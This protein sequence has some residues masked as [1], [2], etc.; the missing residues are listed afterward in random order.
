VSHNNND[1][2]VLVLAPVGQDAGAMA[3]LLER[4]GLKVRICC[5]PLECIGEMNAGAGL[6]LLTEEALALE[7]AFD[8]LDQIRTQPAWSELPLIILTSGGES[9]LTQLLDSAARAAG[10]IT[11]LERPIGTTT[12]LRSVEVGLNSRRRQYQVRDLLIKER[13][14][15]E[16]LRELYARLADHTNELE[17]LVELRTAKLAESN[18][19]LRREIKERE[20]AERTR[21]ELR[22]Q[23]TNAQEEERRRIA[24]ELHDQMG[25]NLTALNLGLR[26]LGEANPCCDD[27]AASVRPLQEL[28]AQTARDLHRVALELRPA[29][30]DDLGLVK[31]LRNLVQMWS[32]HCQIEGDFEPGNYDSAGVSTEIETTLYRLIQEAL[33]NVAKHSGAR[34]VSVLLSRTPEQV[35]A[36]VEDD[37][38]GFD[39][40]AKLEA[41]DGRGRLGL[42]GMKERLS[43]IAGKLQ[44]ESSPGEGTTL[45]IRIPIAT[46]K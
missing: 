40:A 37:G 23:L 4:H 44:I 5:N 27:V 12:L 3:D 38:R 6:L 26:S 43:G 45:I 29:A 1:E 32:Q 16:R 35:Q 14:S 25:Q 30:L 11:L 9:R 46:Q 19:Q 2:R 18:E 13:Q 10:T 15:S 17:R 34:H 33:N 21:E 22:R 31:A 41:A 20:E 36:I 39:V 24:R 7:G 42:V 8:L 28:A